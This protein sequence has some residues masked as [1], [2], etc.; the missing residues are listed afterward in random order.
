MSETSENNA[1]RMTG[2]RV[3]FVVVD[4]RA[5]LI[6]PI[7]FIHM[8]LWTAMVVVGALAV[9]AF[10]ERRGYTV[11]VAMRMAGT[12]VFNR[13]RKRFFVRAQPSLASWNERKG[14]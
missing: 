3:L 4:S 13:G 1:W 5:A 10:L 8:R 11:E 14:L 7:F 9:F 12:L 2:M 6:I